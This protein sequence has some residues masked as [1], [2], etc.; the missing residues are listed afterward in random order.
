MPRFDGSALLG[1]ED[2]ARGQKAWIDSQ[3]SVED[4]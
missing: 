4:A 2:Y 1:T 3:V